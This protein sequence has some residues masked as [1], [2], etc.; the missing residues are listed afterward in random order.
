MNGDKFTNAVAIA[1]DRLR[2]FAAILL[3]LRGDAA[4]TERE[5][6]II[7][8]D[9]ELAF[10]NNV[11]H[12]TGARADA[13]GGADDAVGSDFGIGSDFGFGIDERGGVDGH[14]R[15]AGRLRGRR[16]DGLVTFVTAV[17]G[18]VSGLV[19][20]DEFAH[21]SCFGDDLTVDGGDALHLR[22]GVFE[23]EHLHFNAKLIAWDDRSAEFSFFDGSEEHDLAA[24][25]RSERAHQDAGHLRHGLYNE[26]SG[27]NGIA[28]KVADEVR[29]V[30]GDI[31]DPD[32]RIIR[33]FNDSVD[34]Q[35]GITVRQKRSDFLNIQ[36]G[37]GNRY[38][39]N[40]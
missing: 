27:H 28:G 14:E 8:A 6:D 23:A 12:E 36:R 9:G 4:G 39:N 21:E 10:E 32:Y 37:H 35:H 33:Y 26:Y 25:V 17:G 11:R 38:Y 1:D 29:L 22:H 31:L 2:S 40:R 19:G 5:E 30:D 7:V 24:S 16:F 20:E 18:A 3:I 34:H 13:H 15:N